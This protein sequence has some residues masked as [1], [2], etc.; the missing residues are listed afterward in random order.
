[1]RHW[2]SVWTQHVLNIGNSSL[3][4]GS[5]CIF[6]V[7]PHILGKKR[8]RKY[9]DL[10]LNTLND[11]FTPGA[12]SLRAVHSPSL[13]CLKIQRKRLCAT[14]SSHVSSFCKNKKN[15]RIVSLHRR[16]GIHSDDMFGGFD[17]KPIKLLHLSIWGGAAETQYKHRGF[18][19]NTLTT[20][21]NAA[22]GA[23]LPQISLPRSRIEKHVKS[24]WFIVPRRQ[25]SSPSACGTAESLN[26]DENKKGCW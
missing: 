16:S 7:V 9:V 21:H 25:D 2:R 12:Y 13:R 1:M 4:V 14:Q 18:V 20:A 15:R 6:I 26:T 5:C 24:D 22:Y 3:T 10:W 11:V 17:H 23:V 8:R 19:C